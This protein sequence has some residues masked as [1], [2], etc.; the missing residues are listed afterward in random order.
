MEYDVQFI[1]YLCKITGTER[2]CI[3]RKHRQNHLYDSIEPLAKKRFLENKKKYSTM[4]TL[5]L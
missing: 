5:N 3:M 4:D 1:C 2:K